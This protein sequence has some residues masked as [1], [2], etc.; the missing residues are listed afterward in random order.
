MES[1]KINIST[2]DATWIAKLS[3]TEWNLVK[4]RIGELTGMQMTTVQK[5]EKAVNPSQIPNLA[6]LAELDKKK[7]SLVK[8]RF[9]EF[10]NLT[11][12]VALKSAAKIELMS[13]D[14][15]FQDVIPMEVMKDL[16]NDSSLPVSL[17]KT[18]RKELA[19]EKAKITRERNRN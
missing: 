18:L 13:N 3:D 10:I 14:P 1:S 16:A 5:G 4:K 12:K 2:P 11:L 9:E 6:W 17:R 19:E 15:R 7:W 8:T